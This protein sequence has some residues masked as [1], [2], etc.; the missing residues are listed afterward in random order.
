MK[1]RIEYVHASYS[2]DFDSNSDLVTVKE[3]LHHPDGTITPNLRLVKD[4]ERSFYVTKKEYR[5]H[6]QKKEWEFIEKTD[7]YRTTHVNMGSTLK[8]A[9]GVY[10]KAILSQLKESPFVYGA[11]VMPQVLVANEYLEREPELTSEATL[12]VQDY[13]WDVV[14]GHGDIITGSTTFKENVIV[15][16]TYDFLELHNPT[17]EQIDEWEQRINDASTNYIGDWI[18][19]RNLNIDI[20]IVEHP[21]EVVKTMYEFTHRLKPDFLGFWSIS[22][23]VGAMMRSLEQARTYYEGIRSDNLSELLRNEEILNVIVPR[24]ITVKELLEDK[25]L[26]LNTDFSDS[27]I[28]QLQSYHKEEKRLAQLIFDYQDRN[29]F[30]DPCIPSNLRHFKW[31]LDNQI[32]ETA[33]GKKISK[34]HA[35]LWHVAETN[36]SFYMID[37]M[38]LFKKVRVREQQR[39]SYGLD[40]IL[41]E[42]LSLSK[43][44][45]TEADGLKRVEWHKFMQARYKAEYGIYN[46]FDCISCEILDE[47]TGDVARSIR[48]LV[49][50]S[51]L[52]KAGSNPSRLADDF[53][54]ILKSQGKIPLTVSGDLTESEFD[55]LTPSKN[56]WINNGVP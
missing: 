40:A 37:L 6:E 11:T 2:S 29:I 14:K 47:K 35:D 22:G 4:Y 39:N 26:L 30:N 27:T 43:L 7:E 20:R 19:K 18:E 8:K 3:H 34:H 56:D 15:A 51:P 31:R 44:K 45:F 16:F 50:V 24:E 52:A 25:V 12:A 33:D 42:E 1:P 49:G 5:D 41:G 28:E 48:P 17:Q 23:D 38:C 55:H 10:G 32:K 54:F 21:W 46:I 36:A 9:L 53:H 13:E